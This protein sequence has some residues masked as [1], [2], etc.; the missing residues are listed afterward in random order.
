METSGL[1]LNQAAAAHWGIAPGSY[2]LLAVSDTGTGI[3]RE[4]QQRIFD[5]FFTTKPVGKGTGLGLST[6]YGIVQ[7]CGGSIRVDSEP[8]HGATFTICLPRTESACAEPPVHGTELA[9][10]QGIETVLVVEDQQ[11]VRDLTGE[12]LRRSGYRVLEAANGDEALL[13]CQ[14]H[15]GPIHLVLTDV[16][17]PGMNGLDL[18]RRIGSLKPASKVLFM[19]G[20][21][22]NATANLGAPEA[23]IQKPF[24]PERLTRKVRATLDAPS[25]APLILV[26]DDSAPI[27]GIF[28]SILTEAGY[29]VV[30]AAD[31]AQT[32]ERLRASRIGLALIDLNMPGQEGLED[33]RKL[34]SKHPDL[35]IVLVSAAFGPAPSAD[36]RALGVDAVLGKPVPAEALLDAVRRLLAP[37]PG[38]TVHR[39]ESP[40]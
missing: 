6:A 12:I 27:R 9:T 15:P 40:A 31:G 18:T 25:A 24:T 37:Q 33:V 14:T 7:Q 19:S 35:K 20:Y 39:L 38:T 26:A 30:E 3:D 28:S 23:F 2:A 1:E 36:P 11:N 8:G 34:R 10:A 16:V 32:R 17:M 21:T 29:S 5:P 4:T 13:I 22:G